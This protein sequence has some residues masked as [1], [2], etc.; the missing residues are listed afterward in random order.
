MAEPTKKSSGPR[1][2]TAKVE[3]I[4]RRKIGINRDI[5]QGWLA[6]ELADCE[7]PVEPIA[8]RVSLDLERC[9]G[10]VLVRGHVSTRIRVECGICLA[11]SAL[12]L[13]PEISCF[14]RPR[15]AQGDATENPELTPED[16]ER[17]WYEGDTIVL[18]ELVRDAIMLE[19]PMNPRCASDCAGLE[20][21]PAAA[22]IREIDPR[23]APL[24]SIKL[25]K[26]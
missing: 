24:A 1:I 26:E 22:P 18:D 16:L 19:L 8:G 6:S 14:M 7:Y 25:P 21:H 15:S 5:P 17:E 12:E 23:L 13:E 9:S 11:N 4:E 20:E 2:F 3:E 10:G